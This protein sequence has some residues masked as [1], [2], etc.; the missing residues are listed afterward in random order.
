MPPWAGRPRSRERWRPEGDRPAWPAALP[1]GQLSRPGI[2]EPI[3]HFLQAPARRRCLG[4]EPVG[5][6]FGLLVR[7]AVDLVEGA[8]AE[9]LEAMVAREHARGVDAPLV[10]C[11]PAI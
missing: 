1:P 11:V 6:E 10:G 5:I 8:V 4:S 2:L 3:E 7:P 9:E